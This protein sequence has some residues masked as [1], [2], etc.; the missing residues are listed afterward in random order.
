MYTTCHIIYWV[1]IRDGDQEVN[2]IEQNTSGSDIET[3]LTGA[4]FM[5]Y[6]GLPIASPSKPSASPGKSSRSDP[7][8]AAS[9]SEPGSCKR[10][11]DIKPM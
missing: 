2:Q 6:H 11:G 7:K 10:F 1:K 9:S 3:A 5:C 8:K 4:M